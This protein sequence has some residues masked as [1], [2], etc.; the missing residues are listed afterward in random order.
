MG[1]TVQLQVET[2]RTKVTFAGITSTAIDFVDATLTFA[3]RALKDTLTFVL[4]EKPRSRR[5][6]IFSQ[7]KDRHCQ[8]KTTNFALR[9]P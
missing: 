2:S 1:D 6:L 9:F 8:H 4:R 3:S 7:E 5:K